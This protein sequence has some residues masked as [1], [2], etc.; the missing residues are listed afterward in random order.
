VNYV[1]CA[2]TPTRLSDSILIE[3]GSDWLYRYKAFTLPSCRGW[4][5][6]GLNSTITLGKAAALGLKGFLGFAHINNYSSLKSMRR[7]G[8]ADV[9]KMYVLEVPGS[10][11]IHV[12]PRCRDYGL[13]L[14]LLQPA[15]PA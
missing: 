1:W 6:H 5:L 11:W 7:C 9:G 13:A 14:K 4:R 3:V 8:Y 2:T 10:C 15:R 12:E